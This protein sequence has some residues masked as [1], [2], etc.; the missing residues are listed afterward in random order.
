LKVCYRKQYRSNGSQ[1]C[2]IH[3]FSYDL[4][5]QHMIIFWL[6]KEQNLSEK[7]MTPLIWYV[8]IITQFE[9][10]GIKHCYSPDA[11]RSLYGEL[12]KF[13]HCI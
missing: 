13:I 4:V 6:L 3:T 12:N 2:A 5:W 7:L 11:S 10:K 9:R 8:T 1:S